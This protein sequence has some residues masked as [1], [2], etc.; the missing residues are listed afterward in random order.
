[1]TGVDWLLYVLVVACAGVG[2]AYGLT[3]RRLVL[4]EGAGSV[5]IHSEEDDVHERLLLMTG[6]RGPDAAIDAVGM[7]AHG[8][9][10][11]A[12]KQKLKLENDR[13]YALRQ[14][15]RV[16]RKGGTLSIPGVYAGFIDKVPFGAVFGK[17]VTLKMGQTHMQKYLQPLLRLI[18]E[19]VIDPS[20]VIT[21]TGSLED[22]PMLYRTFREKQDDCVKCVLKPN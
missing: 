15:M 3:T 1:M 12:V 7:E 8:S 22:G 18:E 16:V 5:T 2:L 14:A 20:F 13:P 19:G 21:H 4:A 6:G 17:G 11:D 10:Y 9:A